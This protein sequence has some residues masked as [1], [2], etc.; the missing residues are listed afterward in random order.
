[1]KKSSII[2]TLILIAFFSL[3]NFFIFSCYLSS[4]QNAYQSYVKDGQEY[5]SSTKILINPSQLYVNCK[6]I[7]WE[8]DNKEVVVNGI[9]YD[10][11]SIT[12]YKGKTILTVLSDQQEQEIKKQFAST[13]DTQST[14]SSNNN[15]I[16]LLKEFLALKFLNDTKECADLFLNQN[17]SLAY[18]E[19]SF[20]IKQ[21][22][23]S[24]ETLP[25]NLLA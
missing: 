3:G 5:I 25:P 7:S 10:I 22:F 21:V 8:D 11:V 17:A 16:K 4:Y 19:Y 1:L 24:Q 15:P 14:K 20:S 18:A 13:Y 6:T 12:S 9:L 2:F 23:L